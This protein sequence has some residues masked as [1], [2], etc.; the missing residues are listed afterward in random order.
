M[1]TLKMRIIITAFAVLTIILVLTGRM[2]VNLAPG[3][4]IVYR[5]IDGLRNIA[6]DFGSGLRQEYITS[7]W[8]L[9][10]ATPLVTI[11]CWLKW[12]AMPLA[13]AG[14]CI[15]VWIYRAMLTGLF[16]FGF[17]GMGLISTIVDCSPLIMAALCGILFVLRHKGYDNPI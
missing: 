4:T 13:G 2:H 7:L 8:V 5:Y 1:T 9:L 17:S 10:A 6:P 11:I 14:I 3:L 15:A 16:E 12:K